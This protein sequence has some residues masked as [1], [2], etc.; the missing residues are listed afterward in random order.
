MLIAASN[1]MDA[2]RFIIKITGTAEIDRLLEFGKDYEVQVKT[3]VRS[4]NKIPQDDGTFDYMT[5]LRQSHVELI[6]DGEK[7]AAKDK[8]KK[9][10]KLR[11]ALYYQWQESKS[12]T[13]F[14]A[15]YEIAMSKLI[16]NL[17]EVI[18]Y[19]KNK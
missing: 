14:E 12:D 17:P 9:S 13:D 11:G 10:Q 5:S 16:L 19:L 18:Q 1:P 4:I 6:V 15:Y 7:V 8:S 3:E 2:N